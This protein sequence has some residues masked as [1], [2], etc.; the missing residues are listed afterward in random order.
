MGK[1][2][3]VIAGS[4]NNYLEPWKINGPTG[5]GPRAERVGVSGPLAVGGLGRYNSPL[6]TSFLSINKNAGFILEVSIT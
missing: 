2:R 1:G 3:V 4:V 6:P 5:W